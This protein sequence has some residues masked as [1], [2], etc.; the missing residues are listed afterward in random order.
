[1]ASTVQERPLHSLNCVQSSTEAIKLATRSSL[2][3]VMNHSQSIENERNRIYD[4]VNNINGASNVLIT[5]TESTN[6]PMFRP[7]HEM[8]SFGSPNHSKTVACRGHNP[9]AVASVYQRSEDVE[10][11]NGTG[12][13]TL[14]AGLT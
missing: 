3:K 1:M 11:Q 4:V 2:A 12:T 6:S 8:S 10:A 14:K 13:T 5:R 7:S 9:N